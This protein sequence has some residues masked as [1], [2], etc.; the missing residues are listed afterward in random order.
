MPKSSREKI[1][2]DEKKIISELRIHAKESI[3]NIAKNCKCSRQKVWRI[4]KRL[5]KNKTIWG[6][7]AVVD[8]EKLDVNRYMLLIKSSYQPMGDTI[9]KIIDLTVQKKGK[10][11]GVNIL[12]GGLLHG[13]FDWVVI[14]TAKD[15]NYAKKLKEILLTEYSQNIKEV[16]IMEYVFPLKEGGIVNPEIKKIREFF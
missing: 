16:E 15:I 13:M 7:N 2:K 9:N 11:I 4:I 12:S 6:Y 1:A 14:F 3:D 10:D 5:E 8:D